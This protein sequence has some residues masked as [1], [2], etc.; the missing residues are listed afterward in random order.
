MKS[1]SSIRWRLQLWYALLLVG[2]LAGFGVMAYR[3][4]SARLMQQVDDGLESLLPVLVASQHPARDDRTLR[5]LTVSARD[6]AL[7]DRGGPDGVYYVVWLRHG[8]P[9]TYSAS[10]PRDVPMPKAGEPT[11]R[12]RGDWR[13]TFTFPGPGDCVLVGRSIGPVLAGQRQLAWWL[14]GLGGGIL[15]VGLAGGAWLVSRALRPIEAIGAAAARIATGDLTQRISTGDSESE[16]GQLAGVLNSTFARLDA[17]FTQQRRFTADAAHELRT[18]VATI[19]IN[20]QSG[21]RGEC[22]NPEHREA[23]EATQR[24]AQRMRR[25]TESLLLLARWDAGQETLRREPCDLAQ[26]AAE[27]V[28]LIRP[29]AGVRGLTVEIALAAAP[30]RGDADRLGQVALNLL[31]NAVAY[32]RSGGLIRVSTAVQAGSAVMEVADT[33]IGIAVADQPR[34]FERFYRVDPARSG[35]GGLGLAIALAVVRAHGGTLAVQSELGHGSTFTM[36]LPLTG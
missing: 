24:A 9:V 13:E 11:T 30:C 5:V 19:L 16:L 31:A 35:Q 34:V 36:S 29:L 28:E 26:V 2:V 23:F 21:L 14:G 8:V 7:F 12:Q 4:E 32:N 17:A 22:G 10:A 25:L 3:L 33:G 15:V 27:S 1:L 18:P 6:A 20:T